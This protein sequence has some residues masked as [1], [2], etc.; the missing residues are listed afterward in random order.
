MMYAR[1]QKSDDRATAAEYERD[2]GEH[3]KHEEGNLREACRVRSN[4]AK[5]ENR[6]D[7]CDDEQSDRYTHHGATPVY[8]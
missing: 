8:G 7:D 2:H 3:Q 6:G 5:T 1:R 4:S